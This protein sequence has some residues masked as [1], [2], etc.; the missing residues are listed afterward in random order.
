MGIAPSSQAPDGIASGCEASLIS[1]EAHLEAL[2]REWGALF[3]V[4]PTASPP[5]R[6]EWVREWWRIYG[7]V[8]GNRGRGLRI[9]LI[10]RGPQLIGVLPLYQMSVSSPWGAR[11]LRF[12]T[13]G[14][15]EFE[16]TCAEYLDLLHVPGAVAECIAAVGRLLTDKRSLLWDQ[17]ELT[18]MSVRSPLLG[19]LEPLGVRG[20]WTRLR[21]SGKCYV[22][23]LSGGFETYLKRLSQGARGEARRL[24]RE[25]ERTGMV[26]EL[27]ETAEQSD[28]YFD[29]M[30]ALH[31]DRWASVGKPGSFS[32]RHAEFHRAVA[33]VLVPAGK[34]ILA[35]LSFEGRVYVVTYGHISGDTYH[36]YQRG[37]CKETRPVRSPG[38]ATLLLLMAELARRDIVGYDHLAGPNSFK[39][40][41]ATGE[42][43]LAEIRIV[44]RNLRYL[45][46]TIGNLARRATAKFAR[47]LKGSSPD[48]SRVLGMNH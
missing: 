2:G 10:R 32:A 8:Y 43:P 37:V 17:L 26:F 40:R 46:T 48:G 41:F 22:S 15:A 24:L 27:A 38:T 31:R 9:I 19:L 47:R 39:E 23:D 4:A 3:D 20:T 33:R 18:D 5:L 44:K 28:Q 30:I 16:E 11:Q 34:A 35:R 14:A 6:W 21:E 45:S 36:C 7:P 12:I 13:T 42:H 1:N 29:Q 25:V